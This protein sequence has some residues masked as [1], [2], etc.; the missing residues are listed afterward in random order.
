MKSERQIKQKFNSV[1]RKKIRDPETTRF[2]PRQRKWS[3]P[4]RFF[5][6]PIIFRHLMQLGASSFD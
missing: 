1:Q 3:D 6:C 4:S 2:V 5:K